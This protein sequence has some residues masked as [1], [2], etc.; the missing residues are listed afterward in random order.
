VPLPALMPAADRDEA[1]LA[2]AAGLAAGSRHPLARALLAGSGPVV[3]VQ[4]VRE[5]PGQGMESG[6]LRLGSRKFIGVPDD[7]PADGPELWLARPGHA[8]VCFRFAETLR[9]QARETVQ[10]LRELRI[11]VRLLSGDRPASVTAIAGMCGIADFRALCSPID[12]V[13]EIERLRA[14][15]RQVLMVGDGLNDGPSLAAATVSMS[16]ST[17]AEISQTV[18]DVVFQGTGL[19]AVAETLRTARRAT[20]IMRG[21]IALSIG[22]NVLM[23]PLAMAGMVTPWLAAAAMSSSSLLV[24]GNSWRVRK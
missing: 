8:P 4:G 2:I 7:L 11:D 18:A 23:V 19:D 22:Y 12:K 17:A 5:V 21:N 1:A 24:L 10:A 20:A 16:P 15:G 14:A 6:D 3:A 13:A 9:P